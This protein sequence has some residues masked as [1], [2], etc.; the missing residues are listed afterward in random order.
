MFQIPF[1]DA[2]NTAPDKKNFIACGM[3]YA[4]QWFNGMSKQWDVNSI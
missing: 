4:K 1:A 2:A 3:I